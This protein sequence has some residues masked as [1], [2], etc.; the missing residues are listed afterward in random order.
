VAQ[1][2]TY[3]EYPCLD[4]DIL[5][6]TYPLSVVVTDDRGGPQGKKTPVDLYVRVTDVND[7]P[8]TVGNYRRSIFED[9]REFDP[10]LRVQVTLLESFAKLLNVTSILQENLFIFEFHL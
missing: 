10:P 8:P 6:R 4:Y 9:K 5:P 7:N 1:C 2:A 3:G